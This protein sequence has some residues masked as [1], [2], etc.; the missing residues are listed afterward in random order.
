MAK[1]MILVT[2]PPASGK[3]FVSKQLAKIETNIEE[4][5][6]ASKAY[7]LNINTN[8]L[9]SVIDKYAFA[10]LKQFL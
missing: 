5:P 9:V 7:D 1:R 2:S 8:G 10:S 3:T 4:I 6:S